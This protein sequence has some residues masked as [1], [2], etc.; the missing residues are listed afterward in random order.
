MQMRPLRRLTI[1]FLNG[2]EAGDG[3][4]EFCNDDLFARGG[5]VHES[6]E[7]RFRGAD[8]D[9]LQARLRLGFRGLTV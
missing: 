4:A 5:F 1:E 2:L 7:N 3:F 6:G 9:G 8:S